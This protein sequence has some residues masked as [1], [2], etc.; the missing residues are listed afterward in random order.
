MS[1]KHPT[2]DPGDVDVPEHLVP[3][4]RGA[5]HDQLAGICRQVVE[6]FDNEDRHASPRYIAAV[7]ALEDRLRVVKS[8]GASHGL[9]LPRD[10]LEAL[11]AHAIRVQDLDAEQLS[12]RHTAEAFDE[13][14]RRSHIT[15]RLRVLQHELTTPARKAA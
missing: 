15:R 13:L 7:V 8:F 14:E 3:A 5:A 1:I 12:Q 10:V 9:A 6:Q 2:G 4:L 11:V